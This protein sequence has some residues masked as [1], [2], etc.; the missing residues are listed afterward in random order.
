MATTARE[1]HSDEWL[2]PF[3]RGTGVIDRIGPGWC[4]PP[5]S[6]LALLKPF[7]SSSSASRN[8]GRKWGLVGEV[9]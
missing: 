2:H 7:Y 6:A 4:T 8:L 9:R 1:I 3:L 5:C